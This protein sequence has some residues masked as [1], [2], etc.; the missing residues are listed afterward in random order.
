MITTVFLVAALFVP[1]A[2]VPMPVVSAAPLKEIEHV[3]AS[4]ACGN[5]VVHANSAISSALRNDNTLTRT[6]FRLRRIDLEH[7]AI[8]RRN[9]LTELARYAKEI[10]DDAVRGDG[11]VKRLRDLAEKATD[12]ERKEELRTFANALGGALYRQKQVA[13]DLNGMLAFLDYREMREGV[14][15]QVGSGVA[16]PNP[17]LR[18]FAPPVRQGPFTPTPSPNTLTQAAARDFELRLAPIA[19]DEQKAAEHSEGAVS[20]C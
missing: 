11:E 8:E 2:P 19:V 3:R 14:D 5:I 12:L 9:G 10:R 1:E 18:R 6:I 17:N 7:N 15:E 13:L 4:A 16:G 20:G